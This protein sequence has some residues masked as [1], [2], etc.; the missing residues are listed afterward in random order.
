MRRFLERYLAG[1]YAEVWRELVALGPRVRYKNYCTDAAAVAAE[2]M[3]RA[4]HN[5]ELLITRL[6]EMGFRFLTPELYEENRQQAG[7][8]LEEILN[9]AA[10][11]SSIRDGTWD[12]AADF[13][14][15]K[16]ARQAIENAADHSRARAEEFIDWAVSSQPAALKNRRVLAKPT[17]N[18]ARDLDKLE[19]MV[20][21]PLPLSLRAWYEQVGGVSLLGWHSSVCPNPDEPA[22]LFENSPDPIVI[23]PL[24]L[25]LKAAADEQKRYGAK[26]Q[27]FMLWAGPPGRDCYGMELPNQCADGIFDNCR[28]KTF[29]EY[30]RRVFACGGFLT[31][32]KMPPSEVVAK[33]KKGLLPL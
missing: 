3:R 28:R 4:R 15:S 8:R 23:Y 9:R 7:R 27:G 6:D 17:K 11:H 13:R 29:V 30:L 19:N 10:L 2:A 1:E 16:E 25:M 21:G 5:V 24:D 26:L 31:P 12:T 22:S 18:T 32:G 20:G 14:K 33:L